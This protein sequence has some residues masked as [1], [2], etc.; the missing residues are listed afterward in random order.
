MFTAFGDDKQIDIVSN[1]FW[2]TFV[3]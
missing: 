2:T 3:E 1:T